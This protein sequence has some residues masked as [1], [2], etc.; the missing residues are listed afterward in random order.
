MIDAILWIAR[1]HQWLYLGLSVLGLL[2]L[3]LWIRAQHRLSYTLF[4]LER[5]T[6]IAARSRSAAMIF[7]VLL[8]LAAMA[9][10]NTFV[11]PNLTVLF[12]APPTP[13]PGLA[14][15]T[16]APTAT[17]PLALPGFE[18]PT[19]ELNLEPTA[20]RTPVPAGGA[21]CLDAKATI[22]SPIPGAILAGEVEVRGTANIDNFAFY[23]VEI[24]TLGENWL[25]VITDIEPVENGVLGVWDTRLQTPGDYALRLLVYDSAGQHPEPCTIPIT[26]ALPQ[27]TPTP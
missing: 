19:Q 7:I 11:A 27:P 4:G 10:L 15:S 2:Q 6:V 24:S 25:T 1:Y 13:T 20:T 5:E 21:G 22:N 3:L 9:L 8:V 12:G 26:I 17:L 16:P 23:V 18:T 14:T